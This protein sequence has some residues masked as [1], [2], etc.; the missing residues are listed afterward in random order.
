MCSYSTINGQYAC[1]NDYLLHQTLD[2]QWGFP[3]FVTSDYGATHSTVASAD[4]G[5]DQEMPGPVFY[6]TALQAAVQDGQVSMA[7]L[8]DM[9]SRILTEM[10]RFNE[11]NNPPTGS[12]SA[13]VTTTAHQD[14]ATTVAED[15]TVLLK[16][17]GGTLPLS[18]T[19]GG[20]VA[21]IGPA[22][23]AAAGLHRRRQRVRDRTVPRHPAAGAAGR[24]GLGHHR[25]LHPGPAHRHLAAAPS[26]ART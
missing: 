24:G 20:S 21:V 12:T 13:T 10:F 2:Q 1:Q 3:G 16:N 19:N 17:S 23:S 11:F 14:T 7:T 6:G 8:D 5:M 15:G 25:V 4:A 22:A 26:R 18:A 9:V